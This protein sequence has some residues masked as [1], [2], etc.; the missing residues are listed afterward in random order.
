MLVQKNL[1]YTLELAHS[2]TSASA[3]GRLLSVNLARML[4]VY[5]LISCHTK[6]IKNTENGKINP[7]TLYSQTVKLVTRQTINTNNI[8]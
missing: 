3:I 2:M 4:N 5:A 8:L 1:Q 7:G 6:A